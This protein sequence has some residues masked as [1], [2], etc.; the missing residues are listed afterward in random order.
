VDRE[1]PPQSRQVDRNLFADREIEFAAKK[2]GGRMDGEGG[3]KKEEM[4]MM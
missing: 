4:V 2:E 3:R 1:V